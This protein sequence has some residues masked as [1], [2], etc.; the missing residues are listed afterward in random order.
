M[1]RGRLRRRHEDGEASGETDEQIEID[2]RQLTDIFVVPQWLRDVGLTAWLLVGVALFLVGMVWLLALTQVIVLPLL[3]AGIVAAV[4][5]PLVA[6]LHGHRVP[7]GLGAA[8]LM[9]AIIA[10]GIGVTL[11]VVGGIT[12][13]AADASSRLSDAKDTIAGWLTDLGVDPSKAEEAKQHASSGVSDS[14]SALLDG[15][16]GGLSALSSIVFFLAMTALILFFLLKDGPTIR[17][18]VEDHSGIPKPVAQMIGQRVLGSLRGYFLGVTIVAAFNAVV[19]TI[20][21]LILGVPLVGT[22]AA[23]T[24]LGAYVP[25]IGAWAAGAFAVLLALG[26]GGTDAA[27]GMIVVQLLANSVLQQLVQPLAMG[28]ALGIHPLAVLVVTIAG[29]ALFG[30]IG[31]VLAAPLTSAVVRISADLARARAEE[32]PPAA[33]PGAAPRSGGS[34]VTGSAR[35]R[36]WLAVADAS[37]QVT[38]LPDLGGQPFERLGDRVRLLRASLRLGP[39]HEDA[40]DHAGDHGEERQAPDHQHG[41][42]QLPARRIRHHVAV[43]DRGHRLRRPPHPV[44]DRAEAVRI[45]EALDHPEDDDRDQPQHRDHPRR[46][47][48]AKALAVDPVLDHP[49]CRRMAHRILHRL[50][51]SPPDPSALPSEG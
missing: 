35:R 23:V 41:G 29:G 11:V 20:G 14:V 16:V 13:E 48:R 7:R 49:A 34:H 36:P 43:A 15:V 28:A 37:E 33:P 50:G 25:Y 40:R 44:P 46:N 45:D 24:F 6:W 4:A 12:G 5:S 22:I 19:V 17:A 1:I 10:L 30:T 8:L 39:G 18:W 3:T 32:A 38:H 42:D 21:A 27:A 2:A 31:L 51:V 9:V 47:P 26:G